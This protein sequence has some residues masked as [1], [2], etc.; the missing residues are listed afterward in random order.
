MYLNG[1][2]D[3]LGKITQIIALFCP[4]QSVCPSFASG[5]ERSA[6]QCGHFTTSPRVLARK[7]LGMKSIF[8]AA[9][10]YLA[11]TLCKPNRQLLFKTI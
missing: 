9:G 5:I 11:L 3:S 2:F 8:V 4:D 7:K 10:E 6:R 1:P